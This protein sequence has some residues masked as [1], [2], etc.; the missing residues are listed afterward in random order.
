[1]QSIKAQIVCNLKRFTKLI[2][3]IIMTAAIVIAA[4]AG[5]LVIRKI[6]KV[7]KT[8]QYVSTFKYGFD[9][10]TQE[11]YENELKTQPS[12]I[13]GLTKYEKYKLGLSEYDGSDTDG[14]GLSDKEEIEIYHT[15][16]LKESTAGDL[17]TDGYKIQHGMDPFTHYEYTE[18][19]SFQGN[20][21][22]EVTLTP[23]IPSDFY[24]VIE[25]ETGKSQSEQVPGYQE[26]KTYCIYDF[27]GT[28]SISL[29]DLGGSKGKRYHVFATEIFYNTWKPVP[30][31]HTKDSLEI[32][33]QF[34]QGDTYIISIVEGGFASTIKYKW[35]AFINYVAPTTRSSCTD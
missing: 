13:E 33:L 18:D 22:K 32:S 21:C 6:H 19:I 15:D 9:I 29:D 2:G 26:I 4:I 16:P 14:D 7:K 11:E 10:P 30:I 24:A 35:N 5:V 34:T 12:D 8:E 27:T 17:Y 1:M 25:D 23:I 31:T 28:I 20:K 3:I